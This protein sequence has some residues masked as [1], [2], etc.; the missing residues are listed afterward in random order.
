[1]LKK[2]IKNKKTVLTQIAHTDD[3][4]DLTTTGGN[5]LLVD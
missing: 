3:G 4:T 2:D 1:M 5:R